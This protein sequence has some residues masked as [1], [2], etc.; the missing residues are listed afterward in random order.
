MKRNIFHREKNLIMSVYWIRWGSCWRAIKYTFAKEKSI[1]KIGR[2][3]KKGA[4]T[5]VQGDTC[6]HNNYYMSV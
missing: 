4:W 1:R 3:L 5:P 2:K 6:T